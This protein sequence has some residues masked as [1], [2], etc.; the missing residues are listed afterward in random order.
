MTLR[1]AASKDLPAQRNLRLNTYSL[2]LA[3]LLTAVL[4]LVFWGAAARLYPAEAVGIGAAVVNS[5]V[6]LSALS[7][8][9]IDAMFERFLPAAGT[10]TGYLLNRGFLVV[11]AAAAVAGAITVFVGPRDL[12]ISSAMMLLYPLVVLEQALFTL[13]DRATAGLGVARWAAVKNVFHAV[14]KLLALVALAWTGSALSIVLAWVVTGA[15]AAVVVYRAMRRRYRTDPMFQGPPALP[16]TRAL[17]RYSGTAYGLMAVSAL[18]PLALPLLIL[19]QS[20]AVASAHFAITWS[21]IA[22]LY[23]TLHLIVSPY[24]AEVAAHPDKVGSLSRRMVTMMAVGA[25]IGSTGLVAVGP[26][27][28]GLVGGDYRAEGQGLL[29]LAALFIPLAAITVVYEGFARVKRRLGLILAVRAT[30]AVLVIGGSVVAVGRWGVIGVGWAHLVVEA[31]AAAIVLV[32][33]IQFMRRSKRDPDWLQ[34]STPRAD[35]EVLPVTS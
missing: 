17:L 24:V 14:A 19:S 15:M 35:D 20:G 23:M 2:V 12:F 22:A 11:A 32:P 31:V 6:M 26:F 3:N 27:A 1:G 10:R 25:V 33:I 9:S 5:A 13:E 18:P 4:G 7:M 29:Y 8:L 28:L 16:P 34:R 21:M 30:A